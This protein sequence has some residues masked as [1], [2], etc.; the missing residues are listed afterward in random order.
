MLLAAPGFCEFL[1][2]LGWW[3]HFGEHNDRTI[4]AL[5]ALSACSTRGLLPP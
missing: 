5:R 1:D 2:E 3:E 4:G